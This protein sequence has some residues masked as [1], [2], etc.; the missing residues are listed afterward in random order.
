MEMQRMVMMVSPH[1]HCSYKGFHRG[2]A[3]LPLTD[4]CDE[5]CCFGRRHSVITAILLI[6]PRCRKEKS[7]EL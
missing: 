7:T 4:L 2:Q 3:K 1:Q 6:Y 5:G